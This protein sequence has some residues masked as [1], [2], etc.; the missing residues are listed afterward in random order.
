ML[1]LH[2]IG[3]YFT[4]YLTQHVD[5]TDCQ[6]SRDKIILAFKDLKPSGWYRHQSTHTPVNWLLENEETAQLIA[7]ERIYTGTPVTAS[8]SI[9]PVLILLVIWNLRRVRNSH[10]HTKEGTWWFTRLLGNLSWAS[11]DKNDVSDEGAGQA[12]IAYA[13]GQMTC[14]VQLVWLIAVRDD[15]SVRKQVGVLGYRWVRTLIAWQPKFDPWDIHSERRREMDCANCPLSSTHV[16]YQ[17]SLYPQYIHTYT[18][19]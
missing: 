15:S 10:L 3:E 18:H 14:C 1:R 12:K 7:V 9:P 13:D 6:Y 4:V 5:V 11:G 8:L 16:L 19:E 17:M 2:L